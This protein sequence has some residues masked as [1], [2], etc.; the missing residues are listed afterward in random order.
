M[1]PFCHSVALPRLGRSPL[2]CNGQWGLLRDSAGAHSRVHTMKRIISASAIL[3]CFAVGAGYEA[4]AQPAPAD[5]AATNVPTLAP[6]IP[7]I[8][9][10]SPSQRPEVFGSYL[11]RGTKVTDRPRPELDPLGIRLGSF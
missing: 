7:P 10:T 1:L 11:E 6:A 9:P 8:S 3:G 5:P 2:A 4:A